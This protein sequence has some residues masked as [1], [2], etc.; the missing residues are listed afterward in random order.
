MDR[1]LDYEKDYE[2]FWKE[3]VEV[4]GELD[5]DRVRAEL[6]DYHFL[7]RE[8][9]KVYCHLTNG[10]LSKPNYFSSTVIQHVDE[11]QEEDIR[12]SIKDL[13]DCYK[14]NDNK[15]SV[16]DIKEYFGID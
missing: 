11:A 8:V 9:S 14:D 7:L 4:N 12:I 2:E 15:I 10:K 3:I 13:I 1:Y 16:E 6:Y 5:L